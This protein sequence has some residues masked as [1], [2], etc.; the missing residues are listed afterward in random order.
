[1][2]SFLPTFWRALG[3]TDAPPE[4]PGDVTPPLPA[5]LPAA[6]LVRDAVAAAS[7]S[8]ALFRGLEPRL[9]LDPLRIATAVTTERSFRVDGRAP[10]V[11]AQLSGFFEAADGWVR[12][13]ANYP[14]HRERLLSALGLPADAGR[15]AAAGRIRSM[16]SAAIGADVTERGGIAVAVR[17]EAEWFAHPHAAAVDA[18]PL[19][20]LTPGAPSAR[21][22]RIRV[23]DF[24]RV[25]AGPVA[26][27]TLALL[28]ADVLRVD[29]PAL[30]EPDWQH[31]DTGAGKRSALLD[32][33]DTATLGSLLDTADAVVLGYRPGALDGF[34]LGPESLART[35]PHLVVGVVSAWGRS[36]PWGRRRGFDSIVQAATGIAL[37][38]GQDG[39]PGALPAQALDHSAGYLLA[40]G[41]LT[42]FRRRTGGM[43][44][45]SLARLAH[46]LLR[47][48]RGS[49]GSAEEWSPTTTTVRSGAHEVTI[50]L[51]AVGFDGCPTEWPAPPRP[52]GGDE[53][54]WVA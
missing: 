30:P 54:V 52:Y 48:P 53:P 1:M 22:G 14:H 13:H 32:L 20:A 50:A 43:V 11:W 7:A 28:G 27:R 38:Q 16:P 37:V 18:Q 21:R 10:D 34:G 31:L 49:A 42:L 26:T 51:P 9:T 41:M 23:L 35:H 24:T 4:L 29:S 15:E 25:L 3:E 2:H 36:G 46:E 6:E 40:A 33:R 8:A 39:K 45:V 19:L 5:S 12:T 47:A 17:S 44:E